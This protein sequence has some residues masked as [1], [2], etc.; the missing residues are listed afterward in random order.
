MRKLFIAGNWKMNLNAL[1]AKELAS[2]LAQQVTDDIAVK[3]DVAV[4]PTLWIVCFWIKD[5]LWNLPIL[6]S[7]RSSSTS[8]VTCRGRGQAAL[9]RREG[10]WR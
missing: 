2:G 4:C 1:E 7:V 5:V 9:N 10:P 3:V 8:T 6:V